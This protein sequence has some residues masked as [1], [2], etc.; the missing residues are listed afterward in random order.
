MVSAMLRALGADGGAWSGRGFT[1]RVINLDKDPGL[2]VREPE[3]DANPFGG[4]PCPPV[5]HSENDT[6]NMTRSGPI[7]CCLLMVR[8]QVV[9]VQLDVAIE[10][11]PVLIC[12]RYEREG[13]QIAALPPLPPLPRVSAQAVT[14][15]LNLFGY[16]DRLLGEEAD[17]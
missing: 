11:F 17:G 14:N 2:S 10:L 16:V 6:S 1:Q 4:D 3:D 8:G 5:A 9:E 13:K 12:W 7:R 15:S